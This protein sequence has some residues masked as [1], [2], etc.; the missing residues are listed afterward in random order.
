MIEY[1]PRGLYSE[2][3]DRY[4]VEKHLLAFPSYYRSKKRKKNSAITYPKCVNQ[5]DVNKVAVDENTGEFPRKADFSVS[6]VDET[7]PERDNEDVGSSSRSSSPSELEER[8]EVCQQLQTN[9]IVETGHRSH[10]G[11]LD[12]RSNQNENLQPNGVSTLVE[13]YHQ[14]NAKVSIVSFKKA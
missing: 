5:D 2:V 7:R 1:K 6:F 4:L 13:S 10:D 9:E 3:Y 12:T 14:P 8:F 11:A